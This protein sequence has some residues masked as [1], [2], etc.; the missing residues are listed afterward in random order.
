MAVK[1]DMS[2]AYD[3][4]EWTFLEVVLWRLGFHDR[5]ISW[6]MVCVTSVSYSFLINGAPQ[7]KVKPARGIR[8]G[9]PLSPYLFILCTEVLSGLCSKAQASGDLPGIKVARNCPPINHL[10][11]ADDTMFFTRSDEASCTNLLALLARYERASG[12]C[13]S[14]SKLAITFSSKTPASAKIRVKR[15]LAIN[16]EGGIGK[17]LGLPE[18]FGR[19]KRDIFNSII[20]RIRQKL[21]GPC[22]SAASHRW[23]G[24]IWGVELLNLGLGWSVGNGSQIRV[25][26]DPWVYLS[27][28]LTPIGPP[29]SRESQELHV[30]DIILPESN[31]W[32]FSAIRSY[33]SKSGYAMARKAQL[34]HVTDQFPWGKCIWNLHTSSKIQTFLWRATNGALPTGHTLRVRGL[35]TESKCK[36]CGEVETPL[37]LFLTCSFA[38]RVWDLVPTMHKPNAGTIVS[39]REL[40]VQNTRMINLPPSGLGRSPLYPWLY[41]HLWKNRN[42]L[43][44]EGKSCT[45]TEL[46]TKALKDARSWEEAS[47]SDNTSGQGWTFVDPSGVKVH[48]HSTNR[49]HVAAPIVAE[50]LAVKA[51]LMDAVTNDFSQVNVF[52]DLKSLVNLLNS[53]SSTVLLQSV[54]LDIRVLSCRFDYISFS[55]VPRLNNVVA[56][57]LAKV[58]LSLSVI[59]PVRE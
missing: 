31:E 27:T 54:L 10:L 23:R 11:F 9:D 2:K 32:N 59:P 57:S 56:D 17:Y 43:V 36:R 50:A 38:A 55:Y 41:W 35:Q 5:W 33:S 46:V 29:P 6:I 4:I 52:S 13:I 58:A 21:E 20:D 53:S 8:Q 15:S 49:L 42:R 28:P 12:Q 34:N 51:A 45:E 47:Q 22:P 48:H 39:M 16:K 7:G 18:H 26:A 37:H 40:L 14:P 3:R 30:S 24:I 1:T 19:R 44:F 25:W